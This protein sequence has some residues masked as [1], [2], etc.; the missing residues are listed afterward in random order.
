MTRDFI[1][2]TAAKNEEKYIGEAIESVLRQSVH[3]LVW[4]IVDD[5]SVD[6]TVS[7]VRRFAARNSFLRLHVTRNTSERNFGSKDK[8]INVAYELAREFQ[9]NFVGIQDADIAPGDNDYYKQLLNRFEANLK[10]GIA[11]GYIYEQ[12][13]N[14]WTSRKGNSPDSVAGG[15]QMFRRVC[16]EQIGGYTPLY[17]GGEDWLAELDA[18]MAG[19]EVS[20]FPDMPI[21]HYRPTSSSGGRWRGLFQEGMMD[22]S[23][24]SHTAFEL[25]KCARRIME[26]PVL[27]GS[28]I[29]LSG[30][31]WWTISGRPPLLPA[32]KVAFLRTEQLAKISR[33]RKSLM[34]ARRLGP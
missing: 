14:S 19:W 16:Y 11:G 13:R 4:F 31:A 24:G 18:K 32:E 29:R 20:A 26:R 17:L 33:W 21:H 23:F 30:F 5:G 25:L 2:L 8:A 12:S 1:L 22:A 15:I 10:L 3:P 34:K 9:F 27:V 28:V 7:I 6:Q